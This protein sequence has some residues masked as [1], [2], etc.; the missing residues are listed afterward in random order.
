VLGVGHGL[1]MSQCI[2]IRSCSSRIDTGSSN[3][4]RQIQG[5]KVRWRCDS[6]VDPIPV[7]VR[8]T[9]GGRA[10][11]GACSSRV[12]LPRTNGRAGRNERRDRRGA[13]PRWRGR[14][15]RRQKGRSRHSRGARDCRPRSRRRSRRASR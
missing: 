4:V 9:A 1:I 3:K 6:V 10:S 8:R 2:R 5:S 13:L 15:G 11:R 14:R 7:F 12:P